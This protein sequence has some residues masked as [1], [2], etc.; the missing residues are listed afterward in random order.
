MKGMI[1][2]I[3]KNITVTT[4][5][6]DSLNVDNGQCV[7]NHLD[8]VTTTKKVTEKNAAKIYR[9]ET[10]YS[11]ANIYITSIKTDVVRYEM[12]TETFM[13]YAKAVEV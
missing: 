11:G 12:D 5:T 4:I 8:T 7:V 13:K 3:K 1:M 10:G 2:M 9:A 6:A